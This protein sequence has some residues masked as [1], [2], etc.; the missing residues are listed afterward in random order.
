[1]VYNLPSDHPVGHFRAVR[2]RGGAR[3]GPAP[4]H[5]KY[6]LRLAIRP[7]DPDSRGNSSGGGTQVS[8]RVFVGVCKWGGGDN[9]AVG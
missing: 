5:E 4:R 9:P 8:V 7:S 3:N 2:A 1:M 6:P